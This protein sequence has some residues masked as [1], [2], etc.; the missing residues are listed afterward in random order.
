LKERLPPN[1]KRVNRFPILQAG[2]SPYD[3]NKDNWKLEIYGEIENPITLNFEEFTKM[4]TIKLKTNIHC[5]TGWSLFD[6]YWE[7]VQ[8]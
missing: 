3:L 8:F 2:N 6:T 1:Q 4:P 5:V 7:G